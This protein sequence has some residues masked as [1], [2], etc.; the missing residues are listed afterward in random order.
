NLDRC[1]LNL[2]E[3]ADRDVDY[4][5]PLANARCAGAPDF[6]TPRGERSLLLLR[7][8]GALNWIR[9]RACHSVFSTLSRQQEIP[10]QFLCYACGEPRMGYILVHPSYS[11]RYDDPILQLVWG[12]MHE[13]LIR[14]DRWVFIGYS[15]PPADFHFRE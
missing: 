11:R 9:C 13:E 5:I 10:E 6:G 15:L 4:G 7:T 8:H 3:S 1:A 2:R 14:A 12:R